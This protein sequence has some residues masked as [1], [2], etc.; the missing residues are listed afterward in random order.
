MAYMELD[1]EIYVL[2]RKPGEE[3]TRG[4]ST[5]L[6][7]F[8]TYMNI[9]NKTPMYRISNADNTFVA[10]FSEK[11]DGLYEYVDENEEVFEI[12]LGP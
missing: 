11:H 12:K 10:F 7:A 5:H 6:T 3:W 4:T 1:D 8:Q 2:I 9:I